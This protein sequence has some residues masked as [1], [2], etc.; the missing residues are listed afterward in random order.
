MLDVVLGNY[1]LTHFL[2]TARLSHSLTS[3]SHR[4]DSGLNRLAA[5]MRGE[6]GGETPA[7]RQIVQAR[8]P[9]IPHPTHERIQ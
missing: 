1:L 4:F 8:L 5:E 9:S 7:L 3:T 2:R 6:E